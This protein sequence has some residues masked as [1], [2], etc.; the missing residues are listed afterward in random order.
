VINIRVYEGRVLYQSVCALSVF[1]LR[2]ST[3]NGHLT[4]RLPAGFRHLS[5]IIAA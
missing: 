1:R 3:D 4:D 2:T 5:V